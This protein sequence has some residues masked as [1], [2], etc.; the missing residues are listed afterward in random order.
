MG[1]EVNNEMRRLFH[2]NDLGWIA[3]GNS[4]PALAGCSSGSLKGS[5]RADGWNMRAF[6]SHILDDDERRNTHTH[7]RRG[8][9]GLFRCSETLSSFH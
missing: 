2:I 8:A 1:E 7:P 5:R 4:C 9:G 3:T 6:Q